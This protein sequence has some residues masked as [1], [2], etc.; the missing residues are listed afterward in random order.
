MYGVIY[1]AHCGTPIAPGATYCPH[2]GARVDLGLTRI[3]VRPAKI[4][5][6]LSA[7]PVTPGSTP[8]GL[9]LPHVLA[10]GLVLMVLCV[11]LA[12]PGTGTILAAIVGGMTLAVYRGL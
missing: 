2:C 8:R 3:A 11:T 12:G 7:H 5:A 9:R 6:D 4:P 1:C 10:A